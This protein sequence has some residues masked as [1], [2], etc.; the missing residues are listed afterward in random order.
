MSADV[1][2][3]VLK[4][5][6]RGLESDRLDTGS[7]R[8]ERERT[9]ELLQRHLPAPPAAILDVGGGPGFYACWLAK[10]G[11]SV[12]L[13]DPVPLHVEQATQLAEGSA[14]P[15]AATLG[16]ARSLDESDSSYDA[17]LLLGPLYHLQSRD[18]RVTALAEARRVARPGGAVLV[19][20]ISRFASLLYGMKMGLLD[21]PAFVSLLEGVLRGGRWQPA[22]DSEYFTSAYYH[23]P[24]ELR[25]E[26]TEAGLVCEGV[27]GIEGPGWL[28]G[29]EA[30]DDESARERILHAARVAKGSLR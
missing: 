19:A 16:D 2:D 4:Y 11:Y 21:D 28:M 25:E 26:I 18:D 1:D 13:V 5:Y 6:G 8:I 14:T 22:D 23:L 3:G 30:W 17:I 27:L 24:D 7:A 10:N 9:K 12:R 29:E 15:F 20:A